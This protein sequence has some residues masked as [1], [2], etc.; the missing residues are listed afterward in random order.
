MK[1]NDRKRAAE[2]FLKADEFG[3][4]GKRRAL[5]LYNYLKDNSEIKTS[6]QDLQRIRTLAVINSEK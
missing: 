6:E 2:Y 1:K 4:L 3:L 5:W